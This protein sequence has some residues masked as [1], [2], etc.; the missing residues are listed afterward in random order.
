[1]TVVGECGN[2]RDAVESIRTL[3]PD[4]VLLD[5]QMP[6]LD[7]FGV[8]EAVGAERM[9]PVVFVT[10]YDAYA[11]RAF[12]V[13][14][15]DYVL[16]PVDR[17]RLRRAVAH[18]TRSL[19]DAGLRSSEVEQVRALLDTVA[20]QRR[21]DERITI[22]V[23]G[24]TVFLNIAD[25]DWVEA[26]DDYVR[27]HLGRTSYLVRSTLTSLERRLP[28]TFLRVHRSTIV[29]TGR[30]KEVE[31]FIQGDYQITLLDGT[32]LHSGRSY[33]GKVTDFLQSFTGET[34]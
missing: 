22:K 7:G 3:A 4:L 16:K 20:G 19:Q 25:I 2:G 28:P 27:F 31:P 17:D 11:L 9:P 6:E 1:M 34:G 32:R 10:A 8:I 15:V 5:I 12:E 33:R 13:H 30:I 21:Q 23:D 24:R 29:N 26:V 14:A 18:A